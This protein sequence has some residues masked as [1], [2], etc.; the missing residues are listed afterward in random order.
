MTELISEPQIKQIEFDRSITQ[1]YI[2]VIVKNLKNINFELKDED[3]LIEISTLL[4][5]NKLGK[6]EEI[7][8]RID[9]LMQNETTEKQNSFYDDV[10][11]AV[12]FRLNP[13]TLDTQ[14]T[15]DCA[16]LKEATYRKLYIECIRSCYE[17]WNNLRLFKKFPKLLE[18]NISTF[19]TYSPIKSK[20]I[21]VDIVKDYANS[22]NSDKSSQ[23][24][25]STEVNAIMSDFIKCNYKICAKNARSKRDS[26]DSISTKVFYKNLD[27]LFK[28]EKSAEK[29]FDR[30]KKNEVIL[31]F[32]RAAQKQYNEQTHCDS[33]NYVELDRQ[34]ALILKKSC[35]EDNDLQ[36]AFTIEDVLCIFEDN[37]AQSAFEIG[38]ELEIGDEICPIT[39]RNLL[40]PYSFDGMKLNSDYLSTLMAWIHEWSS[41]GAYWEFKHF[42]TRKYHDI[43]EFK[44]NEIMQAQIDCF[45]ERA[46]S[47]ARYLDD[48]TLYTV[49]KEICGDL[50][51]AVD[52]V[53]SNY[54]N[55]VEQIEL[56]ENFNSL[57]N[58]KTEFE[59]H[60]SYMDRNF[61]SESDDTH[62]PRNYMGYRPFEILSDGT[63]ISRDCISFD[64][65]QSDSDEDQEP[66]EAASTHNEVQ[67]EAIR[68]RMGI[69]LPKQRRR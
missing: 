21:F 32:L 15:L 36:R 24:H 7:L 13:V 33:A 9:E 49:Q 63:Y 14:T 27:V 16:N 69:T 59:R 48:Y 44:P 65:P 53:I 4:F 62:Y 41:G 50:E 2:K 17:D 34:Q 22:K 54:Y 26:A 1:K 39:Q 66:T 30:Y 23:K 29:I 60:L 18:R 40:R 51:T 64:T 10:I 55:D 5:L 52:L 46:G 31:K 28:D 11:K 6:H 20:F 19:E 58:G 37:M 61:G 35:D 47:F 57:K 42:L 56:R 67:F 68:N 3:T 43:R 8:A 38:L 12:N 45:F 25:D